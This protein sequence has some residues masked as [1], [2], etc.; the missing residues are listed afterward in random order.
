MGVA[1]G[2]SLEP[3]EL[4]VRHPQ[5]GL[6]EEGTRAMPKTTEVSI[7]CS[8]Y[9][10]A[11]VSD[12]PHGMRVTRLQE[13]FPVKAKIPTFCYKMNIR[14]DNWFPTTLS[15][16]FDAIVILKQSVSFKP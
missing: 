14:K 1:Q 6:C 8:S 15:F 12:S 10:S 16:L 13:D 11:Q 2:R 7:L 9:Y 4:I 3:E 5:C